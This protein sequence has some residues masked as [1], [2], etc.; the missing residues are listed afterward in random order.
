MDMK[1]EGNKNFC[2]NKCPLVLGR[3][4]KTITNCVNLK[5]KY[6]FKLLPS[7]CCLG[8]AGSELNNRK[9]SRNV[10]IFA[11]VVDS[12]FQPEPPIKDSL[13]YWTFF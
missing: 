12:R 11:E 2:K 4:K 1:E 8:K 3:V 13:N 7:L 5:L 10:Q 9:N 6:Q